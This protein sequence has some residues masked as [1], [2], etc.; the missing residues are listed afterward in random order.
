MH[1]HGLIIIEKVSILTISPCR[2]HQN[3]PARVGE[4]ETGLEAAQE[5]HREHCAD[6]AM[7]PRHFAAAQVRA[8]PVRSHYAAVVLAHVCGPKA[9]P[10]FAAGAG[11]GCDPV[12]VAHGGRA[13]LV[14]EAARGGHRTPSTRSWPIGAGTVQAELQAEV[15]ARPVQAEADSEPADER[16]L[17]RLSARAA[18]P[19]LLFARAQEGGGQA[20]HH[21]SGRRIYTESTTTRE[22]H[23]QEYR[24]H[25]QVL[26]TTDHAPAG[27]GVCGP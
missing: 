14:P 18:A 2:N 22:G 6:T 27:D 26:A 12:R 5:D 16:A 15:D 1:G 25:P 17:H 4:N 3:L 11:S 13:P 24:E 20:A 21:Q 9:I 7:V 23:V 19:G 10:R 8:L